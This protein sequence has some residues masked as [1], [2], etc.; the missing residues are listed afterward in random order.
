M[1]HDLSQAIYGYYHYERHTKIKEYRPWNYDQQ[2]YINFFLAKCKYMHAMTD[3]V[4]GWIY[5]LINVVS[6]HL[7]LNIETNHSFENHNLISS[8]L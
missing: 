8:L 7:I 4:S 2:L 3:Q 6:F 5:V 1:M